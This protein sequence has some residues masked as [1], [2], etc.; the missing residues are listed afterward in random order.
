METMNNNRFLGYARVS[1]K[2]QTESIDAQVDAIKKYCEVYKLTL[3]KIYIDDGISAYKDRP[4]FNKMIDAL[5]NNDGIVVKDLTRFGRDTQDMLKHIHNIQ[6]A[7]KKI[8]FINQHIDTTT[9]EG[10]LLL[11]MLSAIA[12]YEGQS[13]KERLAV[14]REWARI[15]GTKSGKPMNRPR[16]PINWKVFD[17]YREI[18]L[19]VPSIA[20]ILG[21]SKTHLY[22]EIKKRSD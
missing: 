5:S 21:V 7:D 9:K 1:I 14:G 19:S 10:K 12:D 13:I 6:K 16:K 11:T 18:K 4:S 15:H 2:G 22:N 17:E 3:V 20:K 8:I